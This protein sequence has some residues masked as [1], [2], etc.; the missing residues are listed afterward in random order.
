MYCLRRS[1]WVPCG[2]EEVFAFFADARNLEAIT[3]PWLKFRIVTP[4]PIELKAGAEIEYALAWRFVRFCWRTVIEQWQPPHV[5]VDKQVKGPYRAWR[6]THS[7]AAEGR[8]TRMSDT[9]EY[10]LP[11]GVLGRIA[12]G[13]RVRRDVER[14]FDYRADSIGRRF[15]VKPPSHSA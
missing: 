1:Q 13:V 15:G 5:F 10:E 12:H 8:G 14:I 6:H 2:V 3:P 11:C 4:S 9:V 7:F